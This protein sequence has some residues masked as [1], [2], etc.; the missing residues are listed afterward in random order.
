M[1]MQ[2]LSVIIKKLL[3]GNG[4][5]G[6]VGRG[7]HD[8]HV[9]HFDGGWTKWFFLISFKRNMINLYL[10]KCILWWSCFMIKRYYCPYSSYSSMVALSMF[11][12]WPS[13]ASS[14]TQ[15]LLPTS[16]R[17]KLRWWDFIGSFACVYKLKLFYQS[18]F[19]VAYLHVS[20][21]KESSTYIYFVFNL[22]VMIIH[23]CV[24]SSAFM[25]VSVGTSFPSHVQALFMIVYTFIVCIN[26]CRM[27]SVVLKERIKLKS[28]NYYFFILCWICLTT[29][30]R[31]N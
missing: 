12:Q 29:W 26:F 22:I 2:C 10:E 6:A 30:K 15:V 24:Y 27:S 5:F 8:N 28:E 7:V 18:V 31:L 4:F 19:P 25:F 1:G 21:Q 11:T 16:A 14:R 3:N 17:M 13:G 20:H 23:V 9:L